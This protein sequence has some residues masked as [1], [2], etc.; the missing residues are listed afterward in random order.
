MNIDVLNPN[1]LSSSKRFIVNKSNQIEYGLGAIKGVADSFI[2]MCV[3]LENLIHSKIYGIFQKKLTS[4][5]VEK[6]P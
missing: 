1:I 3:K 6:V 5:L 2:N 4:N